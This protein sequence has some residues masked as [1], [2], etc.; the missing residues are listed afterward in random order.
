[1]RVSCMPQSVSVKTWG[2]L[3][4]GQDNPVVFHLAAPKDFLAQDHLPIAGEFAL[5]GSD[6]QG[7]MISFQPFSGSQ[8]ISGRVS[9]N[10]L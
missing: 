1:M 7:V 9:S 8:K 10:A 3:K 6:W 2:T 5:A 4:F